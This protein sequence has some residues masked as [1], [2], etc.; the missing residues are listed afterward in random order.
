MRMATVN[1]LRNEDGTAFIDFEPF[2]FGEFEKVEL[3]LRKDIDSFDTYGFKGFIDWCDETKTEEITERKVHEFSYPEGYEQEIEVVDNEEVSLNKVILYFSERIDYGYID[4]QLLSQVDKLNTPFPDFVHF[5]DYYTLY[6]NGILPPG[7]DIETQRKKDILLIMNPNFTAPNGLTK[8]KEC[9]PVF[10]SNIP[11]MNYYGMD[12]EGGP[13]ASAFKVMPKIY[14]ELKSNLTFPI[15]IDEHTAESIYNP[16]FDEIIYNRIIWEHLEKIEYQGDFENIET[17]FP[18]SFE[19]YTPLINPADKLSAYPKGGRPKQIKGM[20]NLTYNLEIYEDINNRFDYSEFIKTKDLPDTSKF[21]STERLEALLDSWKIPI[22]FEDNEKEIEDP[23]PLGPDYSKSNVL[24]YIETPTVNYKIGSIQFCAGSKLF[25]WDIP[26]G[27]EY[28]INTNNVFIPESAKD[29]FNNKRVMTYK[30]Y[31]ELANVKNNNKR[32]LND[33]DEVIADPLP[34]SVKEVYNYYNSYYP[35]YEDNTRYNYPPLHE[36]VELVVGYFSNPT[37]FTTMPTNGFVVPGLPSTIKFISNYCSYL[38]S[39]Y[40][41]EY[42]TNADITLEPNLCE[43]VHVVSNWMN[44]TYSGSGID[45]GQD[46]NKKIRKQPSLSPSGK[47]YGA[48]N[49]AFNIRTLYTRAL[50]SDD[51][52]NDSVRIYK[53]DQNRTIS[54]DSILPYLSD[55]S[56]VAHTDPYRNAFNGEYNGVAESLGAL[57]NLETPEVITVSDN[58]YYDHEEYDS[59]SGVTP[60]TLVSWYRDN[61]DETIGDDIDENELLMILNLY[62]K[63]GELIYQGEVVSMFNPSL[64]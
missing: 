37:N 6:D 35:R 38:F 32:P 10:S 53:M 19:G 49:D 9:L 13:I 47:S 43:S 24:K 11:Q 2:V 59:G 48:Y 25:Y 45:L 31:K 42:L 39:G 8:N 22:D 63:S 58:Y 4:G 34:V 16:L 44:G 36:G 15:I 17:I 61:Y 5:E 40:S 60:S 46:T 56:S 28:A 21:Y 64:S 33:S 26:Y 30:D 18:F 41:S 27:V 1:G 50:G 3:M 57:S 29:L 20:Y 54:I 14:D 55:L 51:P 52:T 12:L 62:A 23:L 7:V